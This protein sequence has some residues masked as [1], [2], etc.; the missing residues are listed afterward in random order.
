VLQGLKNNGPYERV[1]VMLWF[2]WTI[3]YKVLFITK[4]SARSL[5]S[6]SADVRCFYTPNAT[7][8]CHTTDSDITIG[9]AV[10]HWL[11]PSPVN[12]ALWRARLHLHHISR[13][14]CHFQMVSGFVWEFDR[15]DPSMFW[16]SWICAACFACNRNVTLQQ[17]LNVLSWEISETARTFICFQKCH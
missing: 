7:W 3:V 12:T 6:T 13:S 16:I 1:W 17:L 9:T 14:T 10:W 8:Y 2:P 11:G 15:C 4:D 5:Y